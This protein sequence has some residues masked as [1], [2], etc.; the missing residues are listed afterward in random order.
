[1]QISIKFL[2][3]G[4]ITVKM[5]ITNKIFVCLFWPL[6]ISNSVEPPIGFQNKSIINKKIILAILKQNRIATT[7]PMKAQ[8]LSLFSI[9]N[10]ILVW[11]EWIAITTVP[12]QVET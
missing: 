11:F 2:R 4:F 10:S 6:T 3:N 5:Y 12:I 9:K 7:C 1:M 8:K